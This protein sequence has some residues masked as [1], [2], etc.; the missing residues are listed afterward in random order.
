MKILHN[1]FCWNPHEE[2]Y[3]E[4]L[5]K[6]PFVI[7]ASYTII[8]TQTLKYLIAKIYKYLSIQTLHTS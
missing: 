2:I 5:T 3:L 4:H 8:I 6:S 7:I 1:Q